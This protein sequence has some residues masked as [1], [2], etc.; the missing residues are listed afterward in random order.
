MT[1]DTDLAAVKA[2][3]AA[4]RPL[5]AGHPPRVQGA[6]LADLLAIWVAGHYSDSDDET[7]RLR[8]TILANHS[9]MVRRLIPVNDAIIHGRRR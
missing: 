2:L 9:K 5:L 3:V 7:D 1:S 8:E 6:A 4:I